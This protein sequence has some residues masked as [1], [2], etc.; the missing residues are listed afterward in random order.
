MYHL[1]TGTFI[2]RLTSG[3]PT[4][5]ELRNQALDPE[6]IASDL[7]RDS[8]WM[9]E[10]QSQHCDVILLAELLGG[11][12]DILR[13]LPAVAAHRWFALSSI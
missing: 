5:R 2:S 10:R 3:L 7:S 11:I 12:G 1:L 4:I 13:W 8:I 6:G 9:C